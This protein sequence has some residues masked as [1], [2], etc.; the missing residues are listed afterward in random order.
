MSVDG[1]IK[2]LFFFFLRKQMIVLELYLAPSKTSTMELF[3]HHRSLT[4]QKRRSFPL[5]FC[6]VNAIKSADSCGLGHIY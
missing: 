5:R 2:H 3:R 4:L 6:S 1:P